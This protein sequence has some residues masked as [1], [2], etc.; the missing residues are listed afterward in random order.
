MADTIRLMATAVVIGGA[1]FLGSHH[2]RDDAFVFVNPRQLL[3]LLG[4]GSPST[5]STT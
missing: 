5:A 1:G 2:L 3:D 4:V